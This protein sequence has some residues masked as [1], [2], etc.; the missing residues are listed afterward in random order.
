MGGRY[1]SLDRTQEMGE[2]V[3]I[4]FE[5]Q[6]CVAAPCNECPWRK[7]S[8]PG[9]LGPYSAKEWV[10]MAHADTP[11]ACHKTIK[12]SGSWEGT[13]QCA[14]AAAFRANVAK[15]PRN[16]NIT[17]GPRRDDVFQTNQEFV[18]HHTNGT[19]TWEIHDVFG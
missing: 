9:H 6:P 8:T 15:S 3:S 18:A 12:L 19:E 4:E 7:D 11:I 13:S 16:P 2:S 10:R 1:R 14:G 17:T 5:D